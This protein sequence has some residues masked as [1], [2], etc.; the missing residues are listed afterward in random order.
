MSTLTGPKSKNT[1]SGGKTFTPKLGHRASGW[2]AFTNACESG[3]R[4]IMGLKYNSGSFGGNPSSALQKKP[5]SD[6]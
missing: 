1:H 2:G 3:R 4:A 5:S 6:D